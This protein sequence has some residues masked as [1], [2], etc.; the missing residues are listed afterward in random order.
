MESL[1]L[2]WAEIVQRRVQSLPIVIDLDLIEHVSACDGAGDQAFAVN[3]FD[4][5]KL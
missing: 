5:F 3:G 1:E 4:L 2:H